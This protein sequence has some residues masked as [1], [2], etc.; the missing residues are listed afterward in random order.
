MKG[1]GTSKRSVSG[2]NGIQRPTKKPPCKLFS[3]PTTLE[4][5]NVISAVPGTTKHINLYVNAIDEF[6]PGRGQLTAKATST[7]V[8]EK[9]FSISNKLRKGKVRCQLAVP[10]SLEPGDTFKIVWEIRNWHI[11]SGGIAAGSDLR[12]ETKVRIVQ[13]IPV[14][15][16]KPSNDEKTKG[17]KGGQPDEGEI[18]AVVWKKVDAFDEWNKSVPGHVDN[19]PAKMLAT[20]QNYS[21]LAALGE[22]EIQTI[23]L[24][25]DYTKLTEY[26]QGRITS[27]GASQQA[28]E[29]A[30]ERYTLGVGVALVE[31]ANKKSEA[32]KSG[33]PYNDEHYRHGRHAAAQGVISMLPEY[34][35][36][37]AAAGIS[38]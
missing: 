32:E 4:G 18:V 9:H 31:L 22:Q 17:K 25:E 19:V 10:S 21:E 12:W 26:T 20:L 15:V 13:K 1:F 34:D 28:I 23:W 11:A 30:R 33:T 8:T 16:S 24:N 5:P 2:G 3:N 14:S 37:V 38:E 36:L 7:K 27:K 29:S 6:M 35:A